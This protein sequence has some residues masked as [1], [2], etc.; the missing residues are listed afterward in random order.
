MI[1]CERVP[2]RLPVFGLVVLGLLALTVL[3][4]W[5]LGQR[6]AGPAVAQTQSQPPAGAD[7]NKTPVAL[8]FGFQPPAAAKP[9]PTEQDRKLQELE[10][11][12]QAI[13]KEVQALRGAKTSRPVTMTPY[14]IADQPVS[15]ALG[16]ANVQQW[17]VFGQVADSQSVTLTRTTYKLPKEKA[18]ALSAFLRQHVKAR[19][20]ESKVDGDS[21]IVTTTPE[22]QRTIGQFITLM[23]SKPSGDGP[24]KPI[25]PAQP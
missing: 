24:M 12:V 8:D 1:M 11:K 9:A 7:A 19:V 21:L 17:S 23:K 15:N 5:S 3:P 14:Q 10:R 18:E 16:T 2:C 25:T 4:G 6:P 13:L 22:A 20:L